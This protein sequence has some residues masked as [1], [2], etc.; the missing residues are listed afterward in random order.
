MSSDPDDQDSYYHQYYGKIIGEDKSEK[1]T[2]IGEVKLAYFSLFSAASNRLSEFSV[3]DGISYEYDQYCEALY[4]QDAEEINQSIEDEFGFNRGDL[5]IVEEIVIFPEF[6]GNSFGLLALRAIMEKFQSSCGYIMLKTIPLQ[7]ER[8]KDKKWLDDMKM[9]EFPSG[10]RKATAGL[11]KHYEKLGFKRIGKSDFYLFCTDNK[12]P[13][14][15]ELN[16]HI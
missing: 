16:R 6:R 3:L 13:L 8:N 4:D 9:S 10:E 15:D 7:F 11:A 1:K 2:G 14:P 5:L 12:I